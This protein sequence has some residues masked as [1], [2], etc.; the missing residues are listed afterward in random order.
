VADG[1]SPDP[2]QGRHRVRPR[3]VAQPTFYLAITSGY[4]VAGFNSTSA[5]IVQIVTSTVTAGSW[6]HLV[7]TFDGTTF[8]LYRNGNSV[9]SAAVAGN[10]VATTAVLSLGSK[11]ASGGWYDGRLDEATL[12]NKVL[13]PAQALA[14]YQ[15]GAL[16]RP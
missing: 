5:G 13:T 8:I 6:Q 7:M 16:T 9:A 11:D 12:Y 3:P 4:A 10:I 15:R 1:V 2:G 14:D